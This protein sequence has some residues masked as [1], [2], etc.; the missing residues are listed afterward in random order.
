[1]HAD[2]GQLLVLAYCNGTVRLHDP[3]RGDCLLRLRVGGQLRAFAVHPGL[4]L[5]AW[6]ADGKPPAVLD[7]RILDL[8]LAG[9]RAYY[10]AEFADGPGQRR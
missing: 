6:L 9:H 8:P 10:A 1:M 2:R 4:P 7:L 3:E 5:L